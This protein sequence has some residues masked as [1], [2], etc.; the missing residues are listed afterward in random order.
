MFKYKECQMKEFVLTAKE[1]SK[2]VKLPIQKIYTLRDCST[3][4]TNPRRPVLKKDIHWKFENG[5]V[6]FTNETISLI[7]SWKTELNNKKNK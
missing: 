7:Q 4:A 3:I 5:R 6:I 2:E 1:V